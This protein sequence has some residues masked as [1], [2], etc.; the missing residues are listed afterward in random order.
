MNDPQD[1]PEDKM[2]SGSIAITVYMKIE[3]VSG[4]DAN[5]VANEAVSALKH[6]LRNEP[7]YDLIELD[8]H[9]LWQT[10][11]EP[12]FWDKVDAAY[13]RVKDQR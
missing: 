4:N 3:N 12:D 7:E 6:C 5:Q 11:R 10:N 13:D 9:D 1:A 8:S 2:F